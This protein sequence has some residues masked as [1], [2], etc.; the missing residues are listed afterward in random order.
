MQTQPTTD[1]TI[2]FYMDYAPI[3]VQKFIKAE[4][5]LGCPDT[6]DSAFQGLDMTPFAERDLGVSPN[7]AAIRRRGANLVVCDLAS[8]RGTVLN[9]EKLMPAAE[10][11]LRTGDTLELGNLKMA[12]RLNEEL[13]PSSIR[14][15]RLEISLDSLPLIPASQPVL[16]VEDDPMFLDLYQETLENAGFVVQKCNEVVSAIRYLN[17]YTPAIILL[18][19]MLPSISGLELCRYVRR[20]VDYPLIP[21]VVVSG[22]TATESVKQALEAGADIFLSKP[23]NVKEMVAVFN[24]LVSMNVSADSTLSTKELADTMS[25]EFLASTSSPD[26]TIVLFVRG[27]REPIS[28]IIERS[29]IL[30]RRGE[31]T[32]GQQK[33]GM[34]TGGKR[35]IDFQVCSAFEKGVS[36]MHAEIKRWKKGFVIEDLGSTNGTFVNGQRV[37]PHE[38]Q[39]LNNGDEVSL[40]RLRMT[41]YSLAESALPDHNG[42]D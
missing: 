25:S 41:F 38:F 42:T 30:G 22:R 13:G 28:E 20:E 24:A 9:G 4:L 2:E 33:T 5:T 8:E 39:S 29:I 26:N 35:M 12:I 6:E 18:D 40:G 3:V 15:K 23:V 10:Y 37:M 27:H 19:L 31:I 1:W 32:L 21:I 16:V 7:H 17:H 14:G 36:R 34:L 11:P